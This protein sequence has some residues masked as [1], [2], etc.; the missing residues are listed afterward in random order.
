MLATAMTAACVV[1]ASALAAD[2][3][4]EVVD[5]LDQAA[6][7]EQAAPAAANAAVELPSRT[8][9]LPLGE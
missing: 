8:L 1:P 4:T 7:V 5:Q 9:L 3:S 6:A 2:S